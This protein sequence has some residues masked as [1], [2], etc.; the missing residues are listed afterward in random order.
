LEQE[1]ARITPLFQARLTAKE[2][3]VT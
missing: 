3:A 2:P 1:L